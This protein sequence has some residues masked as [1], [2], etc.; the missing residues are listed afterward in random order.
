MRGDYEGSL[1]RPLS[2]FY[3]QKRLYASSAISLPMMLSVSDYSPG[4]S[5]SPRD[6]R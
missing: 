6:F 4:M 2:G 1:A 3:P 5:G